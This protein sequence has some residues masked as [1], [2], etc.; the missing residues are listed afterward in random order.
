M[1]N[2][3]QP[4]SAMQ[5]ILL[6]LGTLSRAFY[7]MPVDKSC[8]SPSKNLLQ[9]LAPRLPSPRQVSLCFEHAYKLLCSNFQTPSPGT[10]LPPWADR[11]NPKKGAA[12][13]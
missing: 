2:H 12:S 7:L 3:W 13:R 1:L 10:L 8:R 4:P 5:T 9:V 11:T 6:P